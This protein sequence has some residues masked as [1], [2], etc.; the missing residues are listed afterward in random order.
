LSGLTPAEI[1]GA[2]ELI[3]RIRDQGTTI[4]LVEHVMR[5]VTELSDRIV[6]LDQGRVLAQG[7][8][9]DVMARADVAIAYL[10]VAHA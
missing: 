4:V 3:R 5:V 8:A 2:V 6:V 7:N 1:D 9:G 10:G